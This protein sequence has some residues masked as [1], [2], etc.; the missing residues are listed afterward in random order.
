MRL[1]SGI[2]SFKLPAFIECVNNQ[3]TLLHFTRPVWTSLNRSAL[4]QRR[5]PT[6]ATC[7]TPKRRNKTC[8]CLSDVW[9]T[10]CSRQSPGL[11]SVFRLRPNATCTTWPAAPTRTAATQTC[12]F[13]SHWSRMSSRSHLVMMM[14]LWWTVW[15][16]WTD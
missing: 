11:F 12:P 16:D 6:Y 10:K 13:R 2:E 9:A 8:K 7:A 3:T 4:F 5:S 15:P 1:C 14:Q